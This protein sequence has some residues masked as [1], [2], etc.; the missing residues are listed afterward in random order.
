MMSRKM[1]NRILGLA[2]INSTFRQQLQQ[3]PL[4]ALE[5]RDFELT[6]DELEAFKTFASLPFPQFCEHLLEEFALD[7]SN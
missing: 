6:P 4:A 1:I 3:N 7:E 2:S 5:A